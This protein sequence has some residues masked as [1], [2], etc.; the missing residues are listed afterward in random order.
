MLQCF[1]IFSMALSCQANVFEVYASLKGATA[2]DM[3]DVV[4]GAVNLCTGIY[5]TIGG[6]FVSDRLLIVKMTTLFI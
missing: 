2:G 4:R 5:I 3:N 1:P 6:W